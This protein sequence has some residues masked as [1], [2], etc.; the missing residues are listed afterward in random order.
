MTTFVLRIIDRSYVPEHD[1]HSRG[2]HARIPAFPHDTRFLAFRPEWNPTA[3]HATRP[4]AR[5]EAPTRRSSAPKVVTTPGCLPPPKIS[6]LLIVSRFARSRIGTRYP[7]SAPGPPR[8]HGGPDHHSLY[9]ITPTDTD[10]L[11]PRTTLS[12]QNDP[13]K[14]F[15]RPHIPKEAP[16][17]VKDLTQRRPAW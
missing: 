8:R 10:S 14:N 11:L 4:K 5:R 17:S 16:R 7:R 6:L 1:T 13:L 2:R 15:E 12:S 9:S 3:N